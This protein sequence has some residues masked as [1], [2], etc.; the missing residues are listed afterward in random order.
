MHAA[1]TNQTADISHFNDNK[2]LKAFIKTFEVPQRS[3]KIKI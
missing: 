1:S 2:V 3:M